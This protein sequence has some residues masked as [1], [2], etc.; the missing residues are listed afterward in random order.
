MPDICG[1]NYNGV[2]PRPP[3]EELNNFEANPVKYPDR[4]ATFSRESPLLTQ[5]DGTGMMEL[6]EQEQRELVER[7]KE[8]MIRQIAAA[9]G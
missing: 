8:D 6:Q 5:F 4:S 2:R 7:Q 3:V 9:T 1:I